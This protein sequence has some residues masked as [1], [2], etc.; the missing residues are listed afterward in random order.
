MEINVLN[1]FLL[2]MLN[3]KCLCFFYI[4]MNIKFNYIYL[5]LSIFDNVFNLW[6]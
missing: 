5:C 3:E 4:D 2:D 6:I 1:L